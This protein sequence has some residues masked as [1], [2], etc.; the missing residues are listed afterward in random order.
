MKRIVLTNRDV[1]D[2]VRRILRQRNA[3][4][5]DEGFRVLAECNAFDPTS[6]DYLVPEALGNLISALPDSYRVSHVGSFGVFGF[7]II[8]EEEV[9]F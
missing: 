6:T 3:L 5:P 1:N 2:E 7:L 8:A 4:Q 9:P